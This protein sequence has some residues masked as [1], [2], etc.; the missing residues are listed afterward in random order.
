LN[1]GLDI[2]HKIKIF[3]RVTTQRISIKPKKTIF[4][5]FIE[6]KDIAIKEKEPEG[7]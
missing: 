1:T 3:L 2:T 5:T 4:Y 7:E 6:G